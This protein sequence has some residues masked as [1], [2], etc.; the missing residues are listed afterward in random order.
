MPYTLES[1]P[2]T[3]PTPAPLTVA[4]V[5]AAARTLGGSGGPGAARL[6]GL[7]IDPQADL[8]AVLKALHAEPALAARVLKVANSPYYR[9]AGSIGTLERAVQV[10]GLDAIRGICAVCCM[11]RLPTQ[12]GAGPLDP[13]RFRQHSLATAV[14]AQALA[15]RVAPDL[16]AEAFIA[17]LL[18]DMGHLVQARLRPQA[19][20]WIGGLPA[21]MSA[22][23]G[24]QQER[25]LMGLTHDECT[26][27]LAQAWSLPAWLVEAV[28]AHHG[29]PDPAADGHTPTL[30]AVIRAA[31]A[32]SGCCT[33]GLSARCSQALGWPGLG[34]GLAADAIERLSADLPAQVQALADAS[35]G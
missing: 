29:E 9:L 21:A 14:A 34:I 32:L 20:A 28:G 31:D 10:L 6:L 26:A 2:T 15:R 33:P 12:R 23:E 18:H 4:D 11:D 22:E 24:L 27:L 25:R 7:L 3:A 35:A 17:G 5:T 13:Q 8:D 1:P 30:A 16:Q 19:V